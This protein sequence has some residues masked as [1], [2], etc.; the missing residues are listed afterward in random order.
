MPDFVMGDK[1]SGDKVSGDKVMGDKVSGH[2]IMRDRIVGD[3]ALQS[4]PSP[5]PEPAVL[6]FLSAN[7][8]NTGH[9]Q[10]DKERR[11]IDEA[12]QYAQAERRLALRTADAVRVAD[13]QYALLRHRPAVAH[14]SGHGTRREG[15]HVLDDFDGAY[16]VPPEALSELFAILRNGPSCVVLNAC[17]THDQA[18]AIAQH[19]PCVIGMDG[20]VA[21]AAAIC[22]AASFYQALAFGRSV[23]E[24][25]DLGR[26]RLKLERFPDAFRPVLVARPGVA[27]RIVIAPPS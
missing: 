27:E 21:D 8:S 22:F 7:P 13:L 12:I 10:L 11:R 15:I 1:V 17:L 5:A 2:K 18:L 20:S 24:A 19:V 9:L 14:F 3:G 23:R 26:N 25:F 6:L 16:P 4:A